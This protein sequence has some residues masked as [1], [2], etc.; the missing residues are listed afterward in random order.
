MEYTQIGSKLTHNGETLYSPDTYDDGLTCGCIFKDEKAFVE[1]KKAICY[2]PEHAF[3][4]VEPV[5]S[6]NGKDYF[7]LDDVSGFT[8]EDLETLLHDDNGNLLTDEEG[9]E[10]SVEYFF[11]KLLWAYPETYFY[12]MF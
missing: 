2:I 12:E 11:S 6:I 9:D 5:V 3:D 8:R 10:V 1:D 7:R 4:E